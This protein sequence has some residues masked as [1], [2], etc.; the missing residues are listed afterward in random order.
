MFSQLVGT[1]V[2]PCLRLSVALTA[3]ARHP[4]RF[5]KFITSK[6]ALLAEDVS[7]ESCP[8]C[9]LHTWVSVLR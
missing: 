1:V 6:P 5:A 9:L 4:L 8:A 3:A 7:D 2:S